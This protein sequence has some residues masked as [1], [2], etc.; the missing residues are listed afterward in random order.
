MQGR[1][2]T[3]GQNWFQENGIQGTGVDKYVRQSQF[4]FLNIQCEMQLLPDKEIL[5]HTQKDM[6]VNKKGIQVNKKIQKSGTSQ[7][8]FGETLSCPMQSTL[9]SLDSRSYWYR[10]QISFCQP[11]HS[12][13]GCHKHGLLKTHNSSLFWKIPLDLTRIILACNPCATI[14]PCSG[15]YTLWAANY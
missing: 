15:N 9:L 3:I 12:S 1:T 7:Q 13:Y 11:V 10:P 6:T 4:Y 5:F 2:S 8:I 14:C